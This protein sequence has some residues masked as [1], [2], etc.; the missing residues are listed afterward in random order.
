MH[1]L[2][3][4]DTRQISQSREEELV[5]NICQKTPSLL[6]GSMFQHSSNQ[7]SCPFPLA[8]DLEEKHVS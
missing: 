5:W 8:A 3:I 7:G 4:I 1:S 2:Q 6:N